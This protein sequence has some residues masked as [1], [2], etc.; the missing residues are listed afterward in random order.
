MSPA[1]PD[2]IN[3]IQWQTALDVSRQTCASVFRDGGTPREALA[4]HGLLRDEIEELSWEKAVDR[5]AAGLCAH[6]LARAA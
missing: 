3:P 2:H 1:T 6:E 4:V 5:I